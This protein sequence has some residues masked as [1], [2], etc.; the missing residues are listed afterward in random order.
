LLLLWEQSFPLPVLFVLILNTSKGDQPEY[1]FDF[2]FSFVFVFI[3]KKKQNK[4]LLL[5]NLQE[6]YFNTLT[7]DT[8]G[9]IKKEE[10]SAPVFFF[11]LY[12]LS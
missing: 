10:N 5:S 7:T 9:E 1:E 12:S 8:L 11:V 4:K 3:R 6:F 2:M